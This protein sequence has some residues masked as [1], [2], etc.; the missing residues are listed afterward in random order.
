MFNEVPKQ[1]EIYTLSHS[2]GACVISA[3]LCFYMFPGKCLAQ[4]ACAHVNDNNSL[5]LYTAFFHT[6]IILKRDLPNLLSPCQCLESIWMMQLQTKS[7]RM[8][9]THQLTVRRDGDRCRQTANVMV[10]WTWDF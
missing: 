8:H 5:L 1:K 10:R 3:G 2:K 7:A 6:Q 9:S 4:S